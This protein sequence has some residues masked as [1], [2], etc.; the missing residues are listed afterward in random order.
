MA[1]TFNSLIPE[2]SVS[3]FRVSKSFYVDTLGF[4]I[5]YER[6]EDKFLHISFGGAQIMI[7]EDNE[8]WITGELSFP[9]GRG[10]NF[11]IACDDVFILYNR[12]FDNE[13]KIFQKIEEVWYRIEDREECVREFLV[14][15]PDG[16]LL[17]FQ[18]YIGERTI[19]SI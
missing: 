3:N 8:Y 19:D 4:N 14:Q 12:I 1:M 5:D 18:Q 17:R 7:I 10:I 16:Y 13:I 15:D 2:F 9:R 6:E 11:Q